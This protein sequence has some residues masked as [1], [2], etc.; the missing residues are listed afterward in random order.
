MGFFEDEV[1]NNLDWLSQATL[2]L[3]FSGSKL[4][5]EMPDRIN[6]AMPTHKAAFYGGVYMSDVL[7]PYILSSANMAPLIKNCY[8]FRSDEKE[9]IIDPARNIHPVIWAEKIKSNFTEKEIIQHVSSQIHPIAASAYNSDIGRINEILDLMDYKPKHNEPNM[10]SSR[11]VRKKI[12]AIVARLHYIF[13][14]NE[15]QIKD[16]DL[17]MSFSN[18]VFQYT[19]SGNLAALT[20]ITKLKIMTHKQQPI[21]SIK[22]TV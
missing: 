11:S 2:P 13:N 4:L 20:N 22:E 1:Y 5:G 18:W 17:M 7:E 21:Y 9:M 16:A 10:R 12:R 6:V 3:V 8:A 19:I 14:N 15:W